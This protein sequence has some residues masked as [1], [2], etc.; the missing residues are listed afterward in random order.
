MIF[1]DE[2]P[3][4][5]E[6][7]EFHKLVGVQKFYLINHF[8]TDNFEEVLKPYIESGE[9]ELSH[10]Y[11]LN[12]VFNT[13]QITEYEI[14]R[15]KCEGNAKWLAILDSDEFLFPVKGKN[16]VEFLKEYEEDWIASLWVFWQCYGTSFV[17]E[18]PKNKLLTQ[19]LLMKSEQNY[20]HNKYGKSIL[21]PE[22]CFP[23]GLHFTR[24]NPGYQAVLPDK[25]ILMEDTVRTWEGVM[26]LEVDISK[27]RIN[28]YWTRDEKYFRE[29]KINRYLGWGVRN[30]GRTRYPFLNLEYDGSILKYT[31]ELR[32][33]MDLDP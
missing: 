3:Y 11:D 4:L 7:I 15:K 20:A 30:E 10:S 25:S 32:Q 1:R 12:P 18:I 19:V 28:H 16:L 5:K 9:V 17:D 13:T 22:R 2:A 21:R 26:Q 27:V 23:A 24:P 8:S 6:W 29:K 31:K 14:I 33:K